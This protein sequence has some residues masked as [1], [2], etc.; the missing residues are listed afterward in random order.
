[1]TVIDPFT[2]IKA[3]GWSEQPGV[4][5]FVDL[6]GPLWFRTIE[7]VKEYG[8]LIEARHLNSNGIVHGGMLMS[9]IDQVISH[10]IFDQGDTTPMATIDMSTNF[11]DAVREG[12]WLSARAQV[13]RRTRSLVFVTGQ[14]CVGE[15][16]CL[17]AQAIMKLRKS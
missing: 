9:V 2:D 15:K 6:I 14:L 1:M 8:M 17:S 7:D 5:P 12:D 10:V 13:Q 11:I 16:V 4:G 3:Q